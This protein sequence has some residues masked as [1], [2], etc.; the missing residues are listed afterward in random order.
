[1]VYDQLLNLFKNRRTVRFASEN[2]ISQD[3]LDKILAA[4]QTAPSFDK[5]Y[6]YGIYVLTN[7]VE[8][9]S[10]KELLLECFRCGTDRP[11]DN[12][13]N[14]EMLQPILSGVVLVYTWWS[15]IGRTP[16]PMAPPGGQGHGHTDAVISATMSMMAAQ[17]LGLATS[18]LV[19]S[20]EQEQ[21]LLAI[22]GNS[23]E[24]LAIVVTI[25]N[26]NLESF[27]R[28]K[29]GTDNVAYT[30]KEQSAI[31]YLKKHRSIKNSV[32]ITLI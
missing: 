31:I 11:F 15:S 2:N 19:A 4:A 25:A 17:S 1:M 8:G 32:A 7:S 10:K 23:Y 13:D 3:K 12:W 9:R 26:T 27:H 6:P 22:T 30:Y 16:D 28:I 18:F 20:K 29:Y 14:K 24:K 21:S 5:L